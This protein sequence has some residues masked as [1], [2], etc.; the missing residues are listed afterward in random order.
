MQLLKVHD[1]CTKRGIKRR[2]M[3]TQSE[4][5][6]LARS[7]DEQTLTYVELLSYDL[8]GQQTGFKQHAE[9][10]LHVVMGS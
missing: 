6:I 1:W 10:A 9:K 3:C 5:C 8:Q 4:T 7:K 2:W